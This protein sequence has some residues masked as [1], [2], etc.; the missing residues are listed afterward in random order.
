[1]YQTK[2]IDSITEDIYIFSPGEFLFIDYFIELCEK[3][4]Q[5]LSLKID[6]K[7]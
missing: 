3:E 2:H 7:K 6:S 1:V 4:K 5:R